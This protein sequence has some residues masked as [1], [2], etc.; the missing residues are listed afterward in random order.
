MKKKRGRPKKIKPV[1][2]VEEIVSEPVSEQEIPG[3]VSQEI[4]PMVEL[5]KTAQSCD[6][7]N[8]VLPGSHQCWSCLHRG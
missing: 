5:P 2:P 7:G 1:E 4:Q 6:C 3:E 8:E